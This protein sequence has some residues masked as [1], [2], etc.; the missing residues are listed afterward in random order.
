M[1]DL[2]GEKK[3]MRHSW[4]EWLLH[5]LLQS[6]DE[7]GHARVTLTDDQHATHRLSTAKAV[8]ILQEQT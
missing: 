7:P 4:C 1:H 8:D 6:G 5:T 3:E 2:F